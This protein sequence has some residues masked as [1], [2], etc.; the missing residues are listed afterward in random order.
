MT[1][2]QHLKR[3]LALASDSDQHEILS[4]I[5]RSLKEA[6][7]TVEIIGNPQVL[8]AKA[9]NSKLMFQGHMDTVPHGEGWEHKQGETEHGLIYGRGAVDMKGQI[10]TL[11]SA[12]DAGHR[13]LVMLTTDEETTISSIGT[14]IGWLHEQGLRPELCI[15]MEPTA[16]DICIGRKGVVV[17]EIITR[18]KAAHGSTP[19][20]GDN[21]IVKAAATVSALAAYAKD[22]ANHRNELGPTTMNIGMING[23]TAVN[24]VPDKATIT[25]EIRLAGISAQ[26]VIG[27]LKARIDAEVSE[28]FA[29]DSYVISADDPAIRS[30]LDIAGGKPIYRPGFA[31]NVFLIKAGIPTV[32]LGLRPDTMHQIDE[33]TSEEDLDRLRGIYERICSAFL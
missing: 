20:R 22:L 31:E 13:P 3:L 1:P 11:L 14:G 12:I 23:G 33:H 4:Y 15:N 10:A 9:Q 8:V 18:G 5:S 27:E 21:A 17:L 26:Q 29:H 16:F 28:R 25:A 6:G 19:E 2:E 32:S 7:Y 24:V 30:L